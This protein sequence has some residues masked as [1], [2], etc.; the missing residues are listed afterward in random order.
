MPFKRLDRRTFLRSAGV[1]IGLP[2][3]DAMLPASAADAKKAL[4]QS[5]R[6]VLVGRPLGLYTPFFFPDKTGKDYEPSRYLKVLQAHRE[7]FT[8]FS[9]M[10]HRYAAGHFAE[11]G[12]L[13]GV[14]PDNIRP[15]EIRNGISLDQEVAAHLGGQTRFASLVIGGGDV[16]WNRRGVRIPAQQRAV[17]VFK[18]LF[19]RG[20]PDEEARELRRLQ[21]GQSIL[22]DVRG[23]VKS[24]SNKLS[25]AD[26]QRLD[27]YLS[28]L[29]EAEQ[30]LQQDEKWSKTPKPQ[31]KVP[32]PTVEFSGPQLLQ[33]S[34]QWYDIVHLAMQ[35]DSTRVISLWLGSQ[36]RPEI[37][38]VT[39]AHHD[40][41]HHGQEPT[42]LE[43]LALIE[44]AELK[45]LGE[46]LGKMKKSTEGEQTLLDR[47][48]IFYASNLGNSS[49]HDNT[50]LPILLAGGGFKH[51]GHVGY[52]RKNNTLLAN[53][54]VRMMQQL[55]IEAKSFGASTGVVSEI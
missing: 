42:K 49:S 13:T 45:V 2:F 46:F 15:S 29:R 54:F 37:D 26:R 24:I 33:R 36:E 47:A 28:S 19:I 7:H 1:A 9:G 16:A 23:Q 44:E 6:M 39:L 12:L 30:R 48:M 14:H 34:R 38:G 32:P 50:N 22:D 5:R 18:Q 31:V 52:D 21:D 27:L 10:S 3:L 51:Q 4:A 55:G 41:S 25:D 43:Q 35:T 17:Q 8:V 11:V 20:T 40:A 53:L